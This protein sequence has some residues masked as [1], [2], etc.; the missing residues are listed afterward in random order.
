MRSSYSAAQPPYSPSLPSSLHADLSVP[1]S[2]I[3][4]ITLLLSPYPP[5]L[6]PDDHMGS[7]PSRWDG[8]NSAGS[9]GSIAR[10]IQCKE[11]V[12]VLLHIYELDP[13]PSLRDAF[14]ASTPT[15]VSPYPFPLPLP[16]I[17]TARQCSSL[18]AVISSRGGATQV[19]HTHTPPVPVPAPPHPCRLLP[20]V[21][22]SGYYGSHP[23]ISL[24][25]WQRAVNCDIS[26]FITMPLCLPHSPT[27][28]LFLIAFTGSNGLSANLYGQSESSGKRTL[29]P[30]LS[31][32]DI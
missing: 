32:P 9:L 5:S 2:L 19:L 30:P 23:V 18:K 31:Y 14:S 3:L 12:R 7:S 4:I 29:T 1:S 8:V 25:H 10:Y 15:I 13:R 17:G 26:H 27:C 21:L 20:I 28:T 6:L 11:Y 16:P 22:F 24:C